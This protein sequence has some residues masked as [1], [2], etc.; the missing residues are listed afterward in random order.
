MN[1]NN[2]PQQYG[3]FGKTARRLGTLEDLVDPGTWNF[4]S[5]NA[6]GTAN[7]QVEGEDDG[8]FFFL[9]DFRH[10]GDDNVSNTASKSGAA[11]SLQI[12]C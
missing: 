4:T 3:L 8:P 6:L 10:S 1:L 9:F 7:D 12:L 2:N 11:L 5:G